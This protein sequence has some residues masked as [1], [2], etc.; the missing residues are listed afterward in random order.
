MDY[1]AKRRA[2][3]DLNPGFSANSHFKKRPEADALI[4]TRLRAHSLQTNMPN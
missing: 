2:R 4:R 3:W 1:K